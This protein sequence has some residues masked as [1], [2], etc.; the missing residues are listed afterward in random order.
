M[1]PFHREGSGV[2]VRVLLLLG[3]CSGYH[4]RGGSVSTSNPLVEGGPGVQ[5]RLG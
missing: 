1:E 4:H 2:W 5:G 3:S